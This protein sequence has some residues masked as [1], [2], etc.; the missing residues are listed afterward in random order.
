MM[1]RL[2]VGRVFLL[3][4]AVSM[5]SQAHAQDR[6]QVGEPHYPQH[7]CA[8]VTPADQARLQSVIDHC[9]AGQAVH[10]AKGRYVSDPLTVSTGVFLWLDRGAILNATTNPL[11]YDRG[12]G[13]CGML[14]HDGKSCRPFLTFDH[15]DGGGLVGEGRIDGQGGQLIDGQ[16]VSWWQIAR[17]AQQVGSKQNNP[18]LI[19]L[20]HA[21]NVTF[22]HITLQNAANFH[23]M[24]DHVRGATFWGVVID[25]PADARNTDGI[26]PASAEDVTI[27]HSFIR[28]GDDNVAIKAGANGGGSHYISLTDNHFYWGHGLSIGSETAGG[29]QHI[30][31]KNL[32]LDGT[33]SGLRIKSDTTRGGEV[34]NVT[35]E[36]ICLRS[37]RWPIFFD[38]H[39]EG[40][41]GGNLIP[42]YRNIA[43]DHLRGSGGEAVFNGY[44]AKHMMSV[45]LRDAVV[46]GV[47]LKQNYA[48]LTPVVSASGEQT[49]IFDCTGAWLPFPQ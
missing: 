30:L 32:A 29:V 48:T 45:F 36:N 23:V 44:D 24:A 16:P 35:Y 7:I 33:T 28:T 46:T 26:D 5:V 12:T 38:T 14:D 15:T 25:A 13:M 10:F 17:Q 43:L 8:T 22:Y 6:R 41:D 40:R 42:V 20:D 37:N 4:L 2:N 21:R 47:S 49:K 19:V 34:Q 1:R 3:C 11:A 27:A 18:R 9:P 31:V 39:Y